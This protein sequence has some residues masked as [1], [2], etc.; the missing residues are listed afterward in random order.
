MKEKI[1]G[2]SIRQKE[3]AKKIRLP[4][5]MLGVRIRRRGKHPRPRS[6]LMLTPEPKKRN[7][8]YGRHF[9]QNRDRGRRGKTTERALEERN[10]RGIT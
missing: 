5:G 4:E 2:S 10:K 8:G 1:K 7:E 3:K 9:L 6:L